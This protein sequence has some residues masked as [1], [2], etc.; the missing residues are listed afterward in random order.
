MEKLRALGWP[1]RARREYRSARD[2]GPSTYG[3]ILAFAHALHAADWSR[4]GIAEGWR[5]QAIRGRW[6]RRSSRRSIAALPRRPRRR[7]ERNGLPPHF[8]AGLSRR[9]SMFD[10][11]IRS[12]ANAVGLMQLLPETASNTASRAGLPGYERGQ[13][14]VPEVNLMLGTRYL[15]EV[16]DRYDGYDIAG[17]ISYNAGPHRYARWRD[18]PEFADSE[19]L[20]ERIPYQETREY[21]RAV[22]E[23]SEIYRFLYPELGSARP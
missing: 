13:L 19:T 11:E 4:E 12:V 17:M 10:P 16:L 14:T 18:F 15:A 5:A 3:A 1:N 2:R 9:E 20:V 7:R 23:L 21:V 22:T 6:S 8:V